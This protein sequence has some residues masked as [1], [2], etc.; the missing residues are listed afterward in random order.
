MIAYLYAITDR[1]ETPL[2]AQP[3]LDD[4]DLA[5][6]V[7][8]DI[9]AVISIHDSE[10]PPASADALWRH[11]AVIEAL[12]EQR[13][14]LPVRFGTILPSARAV[15]DMLRRA[16]TEFA[17]DIAR[18]HGQIEIGVRFV[19]IADDAGNKGAAHEGPVATP[20]TAYVMTRVAELRGRARRRAA[21]TKS[22]RTIHTDLHRLATASRLDTER[23]DRDWIA[24]AYLMPQD[25]TE[26]FLQTVG[27]L[28]KKHPEL[29]L[30]CTGPWPP[31][32]FVRAQAGEK[33]TGEND[34][35]YLH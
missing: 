1:P 11:E 2:P 15:T 17:A 26:A 6:I 25:A 16:Y 13:T 35:G 24:A 19:P 10:V 30:L 29:L 32:S 3:G 8:Q 21:A 33:A 18:L 23:P 22:A 7:W 12:M 4:A 9:G 31:Y 34:H 28:A 5:P 20:G 14:V 27:E